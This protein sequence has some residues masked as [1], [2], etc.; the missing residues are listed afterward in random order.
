[1]AKSELEII[2]GIKDSASG[3]L[4][5]L[6]SAL[7]GVATIAGG[8]L[9]AQVISKLATGLVD[10]GKGSIDAASNLTEAMNATSVV[11]GDA[12]TKVQ[13]FG[14]T[15]ANVTGLSAAQFNQMGAQIGAM[16]QNFGLSTDA[17]ADQTINLATRAADMAS[18]FNTDVNDA[19]T[20]IAAGLRGEADPL[21]RFGVSLSAV[22]VKAK[23]LELGLADAN[24]QIGQAALTQA[25]LA[26]FFDQTNAIAGDFV[27]TSDQLANATRVNQ[28]RWENFRAEIGQNFLPIMQ[29]FQG[30]LME[31]GEVVFPI[32]SQAMADIA[33]TLQAVAQGIANVVGALVDAGPN[34]IEFREALAGLVGSEAANFIIN[35][36][37]KFQQF[38]AWFQETGLPAIR[39]FIG[40]VWS[41]LGPGLAQLGEWI[42]QIAAVV[43]PLL[44][45][46]I[47]FVTDNWNVFGP[48]LGVIGGIILAL[49]SPISFIVA[50]I[51]LLA[52]AWANNWGGIQ[53]KV[54]AV[55]AFLQP[56]FD[57]LKA[58]LEVNIPV[59]IETLKNFWETVLW[60]A[61]QNVWGW[62]QSTLFPMLSELWTWLQ[63]NIPVA[64]QTLSDFWNNTLLPAIQNVWSW[65][66]TTL[67]PFLSELWTWLST[68]LTEAIQT[69]S[70][71]W[72]GTL[73]PALEL[74]WGFLQ[75]S[76]FPLF[77][78]LWELLEVAG[79]TA[80]TALQGFWEN[81]LLPAITAVWDF[82][83]KSL[84]PVF[85]TLGDFIEKTLGPI[86]GTF[87]GE[88]FLGTLK[89]V[90]E[91]IS[92]AISNV[93]DWLGTMKDKL[94]N[95]ELPWWLTPGSP[96][97]FENGLRG[98]SDA[99]KSLSTM[100]LPQFAAQLQ[101]TGASGPALQGGTLVQPVGGG[102]VQNITQ[103]FYNEG[104][105]ALGMA[106]VTTQSRGRLRGRLG[107]K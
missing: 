73:Q 48:I 67:F 81:V 19:M 33:P 69:L 56:I 23:A 61:L 102:T 103:N 38:G 46:A 77:T 21:E 63:A 57:T 32:I 27:N 86:I 43:M 70:D 22:A 45:Q 82:I 39:E 16:L 105:A 15:A 53:E 42:M 89:T 13:A 31:V 35:L 66:T 100:A 44:G 40:T 37:E 74:V 75:E 80:I 54:A 2:I 106:I 58:W 60:P 94:S 41:Q 20:A 28:A 78:A 47:Q 87:S 88:G 34:S 72:T 36:V 97:P 5:K 26:L 85:E 98:I 107:L 79:G 10:L 1:M 99:M 4:A 17:A 62:I 71:F 50:A 90:L 64:L 65:A 76:I 55:W 68:T 3:P 83:S 12:A 91:N 96:T 24:G 59:A 92:T 11:F 9:G 51:V 101:L 8:I 49:T 14:E 25:R 29:T 30:M 7:G 52:T 84:Q 104:A 93:I 18:I 95:I 6:K